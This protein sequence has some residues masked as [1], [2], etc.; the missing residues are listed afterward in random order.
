M[1]TAWSA[2]HIEIPLELMAYDA[3]AAFMANDIESSVSGLS[4]ICS[5]PVRTFDRSVQM[6]ALG[7]KRTYAAQQVMSALP[8]IATAKA[9]FCRAKGHVRFTSKADIAVQLGM[10][11]LRQ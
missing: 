9:D 11:A 3:E 4:N 7:Q 5:Y 8:P 1:R 6:S 2:L 10:S